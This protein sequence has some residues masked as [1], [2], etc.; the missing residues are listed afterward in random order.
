MQDAASLVRLIGTLQPFVYF[1]AVSK[2][3]FELDTNLK[4]Y[5][6]DGRKYLTALSKDYLL[7]AS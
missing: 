4:G 1:T 7:L 2:K 3:Y 6:F 5:F